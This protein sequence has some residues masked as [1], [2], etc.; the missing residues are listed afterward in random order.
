MNEWCGMNGVTAK[1]QRQ[2]DWQDSTDTSQ[3]TTQTERKFGQ[4]AT[5]RVLELILMRL[6]AL[7]RVLKYCYLEGKHNKRVDRLIS[8]LRKLTHDKIFDRLIKITKK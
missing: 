6:E 4:H 7:H 1:E 5:D 2:M 8:V 3:N